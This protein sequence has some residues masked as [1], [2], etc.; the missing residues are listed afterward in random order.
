MQSAHN[1]RACIHVCL[2]STGNIDSKM[3][4][5]KSTVVA[6]IPVKLMYTLSMRNKQKNMDFEN[7]RN[8]P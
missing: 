5:I 8:G 2:S 3:Y 6:D 1:T 4:L 7:K